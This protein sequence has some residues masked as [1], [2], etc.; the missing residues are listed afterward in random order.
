MSPRAWLLI[1]ICGSTIITINMGVR[2]SFGLYLPQISEF[3]GTGRELFSLAIALQNLIWGFSSPFFGGLA[4]RYGPRKVT[5][6]GGVLY[7]AGMLA[8]ALAATGEAIIFGQI[9][10]GIG[11]G[12]AGMSVVLGAVASAAP[13]EKRSMALGL[14]SAGGSFGMFAMLPIAELFLD[15][16]GPFDAL[17][18]MSLIAASMIG[19]AL[20]MPPEKSRAAGEDMTQSLGGALKEAFTHRGYVL[21]TIGF[22]V[23]GFQVVFVSTHLPAFLHDQGLDPKYAGWSLA[24]VGLFNIIGSLAAGWLGGRYSKRNSL[25]LIYTGRSLVMIA[26]LLLPISGASALLFG[27]V[28][29]LLWLGTIPLT[30]GLVAVFFGTRYLSMLYGVVFASHQLGSFLGAWAPGFIYDQVGNYDLAWQA[31]IAS[32]F[33]ATILHLLIKEAPSDRLRKLEAA[34]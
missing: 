32:G 10:I 15:A 19:L 23:C 18:Y 26:F 3:L 16:F 4:D 31:M 2:Q 14:V 1:L 9:L 34:E 25:A 33:V 12:G 29:G 5:M 11:L 30:S 27:A 21:L 6:A 22:F 13:P 28:M 8:M 7:T 17:L 20:G 24:L